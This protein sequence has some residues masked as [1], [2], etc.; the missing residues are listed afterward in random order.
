MMLQRR[1]ENYMPIPE[2]AMQVATAEQHA[3]DERIERLDTKTGVILGFVVVS[4]AEILGFLLLVAGEKNKLEV[5]HRNWFEAVLVF[6]LVCVSLATVFGCWELIPRKTHIGFFLK[7]IKH[8]DPALASEDKQAKATFL[9]LEDAAASKHRVLVAKS[10]LMLLTVLCTTLA[11]FAYVVLVA[12]LLV[13][14]L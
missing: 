11:I 5:L 6:A 4:V 7:F 12:F 8:L 13:S 2:F 9:L 1:K 3:I 10:W 14:V